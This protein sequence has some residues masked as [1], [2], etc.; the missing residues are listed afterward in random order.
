VIAAVG[1]RA[2]LG[3]R[4]VVESLA[5]FEEEVLM[6]AEDN[7]AVAEQLL[8]A[9]NNSDF[10]AAEELVASDFVNHNP[11]PIPGVGSDR[12]G[13]LTAMRYLRQAFPEG[14]AESLNVV[15]EGDKVVLHDVV[16]GTHDGDF[17]GVSPTGARSRSSS[18][19]SSA[20]RTAVS[21]SVGA[22][23]TQWA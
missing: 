13:M 18:S 4:E 2:L 1:S 14:R 3:A 6:S 9:W 11:P 19:T 12:G 16:R 5:T 15:A 7:K 20:W 17:M 21:S 23:R 22:W 10:D 8:D